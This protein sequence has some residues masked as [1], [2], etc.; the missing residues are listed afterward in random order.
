MTNFN[1]QE[2]F[3]V[4][5]H[6]KLQPLICVPPFSEASLGVE[7]GQSGFAPATSAQLFGSLVGLGIGDALGEPLVDGKGRRE[8]EED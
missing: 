5:A 7:S 2:R 8:G 4:D 6:Q 3:G 1:T